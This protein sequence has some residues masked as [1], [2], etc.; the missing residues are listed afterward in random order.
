MTAS[1]RISAIVL[2]FLSVLVVALTSISNPSTLAV[3]R[4]ISNENVNAHPQSCCREWVF[5]VELPSIGIAPGQTLRYSLSYIRPPRSSS[6]LEP[7]SIR[8]KLLADDGSVIAQDEAAAVEAGDVR[9]FDFDRARISL[10]GE[11]E[12]GRLQVRPQAT[13]QVRRR[14]LVTTL[15]IDLSFESTVEII[16]IAT[17][18]TTV[19][20]PGGV[21]E[22]SLDD[23]P[24]NEQPQVKS[25]QILSAGRD[26]V[27]GI[28]P[29]QSLL[30]TTLNTTD[31]ESHGQAAAV[32]A[33][34]QAYD[35]DGHVIAE[36]DVVDVLPDRSHTVRFKHEDLHLNG[37]AG[38][39][40]KQA[41]LRFFS[42]IDRTN[43][44]PDNKPPGIV[45]V[46]FETVDDSTGWT[47]SA[48]KYLTLRPLPLDPP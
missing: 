35:K 27:Y 36:S 48:G 7:A 23:S 34:V 19:R 32:S 15:S 2:S 24:G 12:T 3:A 13:I 11:S 39:G 4:S 22:I 21:N 10:T 29:G 26:G 31:P 42:L 47:V 14:N 37:E 41:R 33:Q 46:S 38:T 5:G 20:I 1:S 17:G 45:L 18:R 6:D 44:V 28:V 43:R 8:V 16:D 30:V 40:R 9:S 25:H